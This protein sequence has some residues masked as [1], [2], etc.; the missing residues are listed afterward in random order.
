MGLGVLGENLIVALLFQSS[1][2]DEDE[3]YSLA[4]T[5]KRLSA[6]YK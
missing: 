4:A 6:F 1:F 2:L 3:V 5:L